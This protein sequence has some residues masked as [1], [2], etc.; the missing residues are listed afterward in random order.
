[1]GMQFVTSGWSFPF[2]PFSI[3]HQILEEISIGLDRLDLGR[4]TMGL[5]PK[6]SPKALANY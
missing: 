1:L 5:Y 4:R 6:F 2:V 3:P